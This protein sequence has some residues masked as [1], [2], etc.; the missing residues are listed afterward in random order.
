MDYLF[1][2]PIVET[3]ISQKLINRIINGKE[4]ITVDTGKELGIYS[5]VNDEWTIN[6]EIITDKPLPTAAT[7][8]KSA[9]KKRGRKPKSELPKID[10]G[11]LEDIGDIDID[12]IDFDNLVL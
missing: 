6:Q 3:S 9:P 2:Q 5:G 1:G 11:G 10:L 4:N 8:K 7:P 12:D